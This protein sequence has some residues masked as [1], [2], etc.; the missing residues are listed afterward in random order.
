MDD[1]VALLDALGLPEVDAFGWSMGGGVVARLAIDHPGRVR[2]LALQAPIS[3]YGYG[4]TRGEDGELVFADAAGT[5]GGG[6]NPRLVELLAAKD[7]D[8]QVTTA[9]STRHHDAEAHPV[10]TEKPPARGTT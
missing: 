2:S 8:G 3:P 4:C 5:G 6:A 10:H 9:T 7:A 1:L